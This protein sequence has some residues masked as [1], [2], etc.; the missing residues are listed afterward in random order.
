[1]ENIT[2]SDA[3]I[4]YFATAKIGSTETVFAGT[5]TGNIYI[6]SGSTGWKTIFE[7][8]TAENTDYLPY[9]GWKNDTYVNDLNGI[10]V[11]PIKAAKGLV[12]L[13]VVT[14]S[15]IYTQDNPSADIVNNAPTFY[16]NVNG[17]EEVCVNA[18]TASPN[19]KLFAGIMDFSGFR[20]DDI[21]NASTVNAISKAS[22][23]NTAIDQDGHI[24]RISSFDFSESNPA[25]MAL[26]A[27]LWNKDMAFVAVSSDGGET[28]A[29]KETGVEGRAMGDVAVAANVLE[30]K[31][32][33]VIVAVPRKTGSTS[34]PV[35]WSDD[36]GETWNN[37]TGL[38]T[39]ILTGTYNYSRNI[40]ESDRVNANV[41]YAYDYARGDF[42]V[43]TDSGAT[44]AKTFTVLGVSETGIATTVKA[45]P[46]KAGEVYFTAY[47]K[48]LYHSTDAGKN[49]V[50]V[51]GVENVEAFSFGKAKDSGSPMSMYVL[52]EVKGVRGLYR[53]DDGGSVW[54]K[55]NGSS[56]GLGCFV[57]CIEGDRNTFGRV[58]VGTGGR[59]IMTAGLEGGDIRVMLVNDDSISSNVGSGRQR[60]AIDLGSDIKETAAFFAAVYNGEGALTRMIAH[61]DIAVG[62]WADVSFTLTSDELSDSGLKVKCFLWSADGKLK[63]LVDTIEPFGLAR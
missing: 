51:S 9:M 10:G 22:S 50:K 47:D 8:F 31:N 54:N 38:P 33:P 32:A 16:A 40:I 45:N 43:S 62:G 25:Y 15:G 17:I 12:E 59:G 18:M 3:I 63:P 27:D 14:G 49:F 6:K 11:N 36:L 42:Y 2:P 61:D 35:V 52:A 46:S 28:W 29:K 44:F 37:S 55:L 1:M 20:I 19:G 5:K 30:G 24:G 57:S 21:N 23:A 60:I 48:G 7:R 41:F 13:W 34:Y 26:Y 58:Y 4:R 39:D 53:S 56:I